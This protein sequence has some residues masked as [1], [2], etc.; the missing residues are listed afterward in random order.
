[1]HST[2]W[3]PYTTMTLLSTRVINI[4]LFIYLDI[5]IFIDGIYLYN[6]LFPHLFILPIYFILLAY[7]FHYLSIYLFISHVFLFNTSSC[8]LY[9]KFNY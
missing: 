6:S 8:T 7:L 1:M 3:I 4:Y 2:C 9:L 5:H